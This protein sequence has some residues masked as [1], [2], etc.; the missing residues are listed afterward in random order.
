MPGK[1]LPNPG[2]GVN[3]AFLKHR[4]LPSREI[5][6]LEPRRYRVLL[7]ILTDKN[8]MPETVIVKDQPEILYLKCDAELREI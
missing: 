4:Y 7:Q 1:V 5:F 3:E 2:E 8:P 6:H